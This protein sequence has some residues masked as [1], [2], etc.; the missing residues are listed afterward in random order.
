MIERG[1]ETD[2]DRQTD[3]QRGVHTQFKYLIYFCLVLVVVDFFPRKIQAYSDALSDAKICPGVSFSTQ[4]D[5]KWWKAHRAAV[6]SNNF[7][8]VTEKTRPG[9][10][11]EDFIVCC[12]LV[13]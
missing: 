6:L 10:S 9:K 3:R 1:R 12:L 8:L 5:C 4:I 13:A 11:Q 7:L 2:P